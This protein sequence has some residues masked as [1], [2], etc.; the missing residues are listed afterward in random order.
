MPFLADDNVCGR[1]LL[2]LV[3]R[4]NAIVAEILRMKDH[5]NV[6]TSVPSS[7]SNTEQE[8]FYGVKKSVF[9]SILFD[10]K[11]LK[12]PEKYEEFVTSSE[13]LIELDEVFHVRK[14][15]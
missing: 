7:K 1:T 10:F 8:R 11:Y 15:H 6:F 2:K 5:I 9:E 13:K 12:A 14:L 4:G 3:A